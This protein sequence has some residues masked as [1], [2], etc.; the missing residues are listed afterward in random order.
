MQGDGIELDVMSW[1]LASDKADVVEARR[2]RG[3]IL[4]GLLC[5]L[6]SFAIAPILISIRRMSG[7]SGL[8]S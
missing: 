3:A 5:D 4:G 6:R 2:T 1:K 7:A 8:V